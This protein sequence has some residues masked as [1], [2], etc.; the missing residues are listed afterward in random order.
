MVYRDNSDSAED[1]AS[2]GAKGLSISEYVV[3][4]CVCVFLCLY[5]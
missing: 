5:F 1:N 3:Y 2:E 4:T